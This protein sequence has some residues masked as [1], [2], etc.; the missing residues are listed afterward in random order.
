MGDKINRDGDDVYI[1]NEL[2]GMWDKSKDTFRLMLDKYEKELTFTITDTNGKIQKMV[3]GGNPK[4]SASSSA[5]ALYS[6][7]ST[8]V[9]DTKFIK[10][11][12]DTSMGKLLLFYNFFFTFSRFSIFRLVKPR[13]DS[14]KV[15]SW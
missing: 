13:I 10:K 8:F 3:F 1:F 15:V 14:G 4:A 7:L 9:P 11:D 5:N 6:W 12:N 2:T